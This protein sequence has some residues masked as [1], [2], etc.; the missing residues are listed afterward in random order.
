LAV[1]ENSLEILNSLFSTTSDIQHA[2]TK[3]LVLEDSEEKKL[4]REAN[5]LS[6]MIMRLEEKF[7]NWFNSQEVQEE[8][9]MM[10]LLSKVQKLTTRQGNESY[11]A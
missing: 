8:L 4:S 5:E 9:K 11:C 1:K 3:V 10:S 7:Y 2:M 6:K